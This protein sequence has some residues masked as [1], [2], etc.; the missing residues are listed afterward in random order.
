MFCFDLFVAFIGIKTKDLELKLT[1]APNNTVALK[2]VK[3]ASL[4]GWQ[5]QTNSIWAQKSQKTWNALLIACDTEPF[6][7]PSLA[8]GGSGSG[9]GGDYSSNGMIK[10]NSS[11]DDSSVSNDPSAM[12]P[13]TPIPL[14]ASVVTSHTV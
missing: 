7:T 10:A 5:T 8:T 1:L 9:T 3:L 6:L 12:T 2:Y 4:R 13:R 14:D 11:S